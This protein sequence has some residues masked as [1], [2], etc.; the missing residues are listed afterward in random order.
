MTKNADIIQNA[1]AMGFQYERDCNNCCQS[2]IAAIQDI[3]G[4]QNESVFKAGSGMAGGIGILCDG[5]CGGYSGGVMVLSTLFGRD[6]A[7]FKDPEVLMPSFELASLL[8]ERYMDSDSSIMVGFNSVALPIIS[9][10]RI[11]S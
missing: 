5:V 7:H 2:T 9:R 10:T 4:V 11:V 1:R 6:R 8:H 3:L